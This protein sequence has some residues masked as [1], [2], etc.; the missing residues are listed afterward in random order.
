M[1]RLDE[2]PGVLDQ[3]L[4]PGELVVE[5]GAGLRIAV[6]QVDRREEDA[7]GGRLQVARL[8]VG[9]VARQGSAR[10]DGLRAA[11]QEG[12]A[13][14]GAL[15]SPGRAVAG[16]L[17]RRRREIAVDRLQLLQR[18]D[19]RRGL[20]E[21]LEQERQAPDDAVDVPGRDLQ[22]RRRRRGRM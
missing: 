3:A 8:A 20:R 21:P 16:R 10:D 9:V 12:D 4:E 14:P 19:V 18:D 17:D 1:P 5:L 15:A 2:G 13:V 11:R 7:E 6:G 22:R